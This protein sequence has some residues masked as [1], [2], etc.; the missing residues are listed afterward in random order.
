MGKVSSAASTRVGAVAE[1]VRAAITDGRFKPGE[2]LLEIQLAAQLGVS[3][4]PVRAALQ[5]LASESLLDHAPHRGFAVR[6]F[7][8]AEIGDAFEVRAALEGLGARLAAER[9][10]T[11][12]ETAAIEK[13]LLDGDALLA[14]GTLDEA[15]RAPYGAI[16]AAFHAALHRAAQSRPVM[17]VLRLCQNIPASALTNVVAFEFTDVRRR[18]D[19]HHRIYEAIVAREPWRAE[20]VMREHVVSVKAALLRTLG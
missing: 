10:L 8:V 18:H 19:D 14:R 1:R 6:R 13:T 5:T 20:M 4:T 15:D 9:G 3:R 17:D 11:A 12:Q 2:R 16:N 7:D